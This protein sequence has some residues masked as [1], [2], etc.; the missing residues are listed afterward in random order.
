MAE[1]P[2]GRGTLLAGR[3]Q[4]EDLLDE[5]DGARFWRATDRVLA[6]SV[7]VHVI[8]A[9][10]ARAAA[11]LSAAR[12]SATVT[13]GHLLRVLDAAV[14]D[15]AAYVVNEWGSGV[16]LDRM[17]S[18]SALSS[19][20]AAWVVKEVAEAI[21]TAHRHG[22]AHGRLIPENVMVTEAGSVKLI[23]F[24]VDA[25]LHGGGRQVRPDDRSEISDHEA[26]VVNLAG[27]LYACLVGRWPGV[28]SSA[29]PDAPRDHGAALR[30]RQVR[31]GIPRPLDAICD[32]VLNP[33]ARGRP[34]IETAHEVFAAL[35]DYI[36]DP[37]A[38][39][40][41]G[42]TTVLDEGTRAAALSGFPFPAD[43]SRHDAPPSD[44]D[45][46]PDPA[47]TS[48]DGPATVA[49]AGA[50]APN[51]DRRPTPPGPRHDPD[52]TQAG[53]PVFD[54]SRARAPGSSGSGELPA[55]AFA[56]R[57]PPPPPPPLVEPEPKPLFADGPRRFP[58]DAADDP[59]ASTSHAWTSTAP[60]PRN[61]SL[62]PYW[63]PDAHPAPDDSA[64]DTGSWPQDESPPGSTWLRL[65]AVIGG[66]V[67]LVLAVVFAFNLGRGSG[68]LGGGGTDSGG[69]SG[70]GTRSA[71]PSRPLTVA[72]VSDFDP[73]GSPPSENPQ[74]APLA[75]DGK[76][77]TS[78]RTMTYYGNPALGGLKDGVGLAVDLGSRKRLGSVALRLV[79]S[80]TTVE[81]LRAPGSTK[82]TSTSG[83]T[84]VGGAAGAGTS[85][86]IKLDKPVR[87]QWFVVWLT[88]LPAVSGGYQGGVA[89]IVPRS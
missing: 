34:P 61:G 11:L 74:L 31:A 88:S 25:V 21:T 76:A 38:A 72:A 27:V 4:L 78:W 43:P 5:A 26:D 59:A 36:G 2:V 48:P 33:G 32:R 87:T 66:I 47:D 84:K 64:A 54:D 14:E 30:P 17:I 42:Q 69:G 35:S 60:G 41:M 39:D 51:R 73:E 9:S 68:P 1:T 19:R 12:A 53:E 50:E 20:R 49:G 6:R 82:P 3:F 13:D 29:L 40:A 56:Q 15:E 63:G 75:V 58:Q 7:A 8:P 89:E 18:E 85:V 44:G 23:G 24:V 46:G 81:I 71:A 22:V 45:P 62:P 80:P 65:A 16:S 79:G 52:A 86:T 37:A 57:T 70:T 83:L 10:D 77:G 55:D 28:G 67:M